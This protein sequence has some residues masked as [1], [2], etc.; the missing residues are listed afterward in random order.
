MP[1]PQTKFNFLMRLCH[2]DRQD[3]VVYSDKN[4][5][6]IQTRFVESWVRVS[7]HFRT[8]YAQIS[9]EY[10]HDEWYFQKPGYAV[11]SDKVMLKFRQELA[12]CQDKCHYIFYLYRCLYS[13]LRLKILIFSYKMA[14]SKENI[15]DGNNRAVSPFVYHLFSFLMID[16]TVEK[17]LPSTYNENWKK[18]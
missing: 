5:L 13:S 7:L 2:I 12:Y 10:E 18:Y 4:S 15:T 6:Y 9:K 11:S 17:F 16:H 14:I 3:Y 8:R 1:Y